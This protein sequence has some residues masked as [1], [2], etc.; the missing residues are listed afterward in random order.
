MLHSNGKTTAFDRKPITPIP[1]YSTDFTDYAHPSPT[2]IT[3]TT[4]RVPYKNCPGTYSSTLPHRISIRHVHTSSIAP[5]LFH[6]RSGEF[7]NKPI[8]NFPA[9]LHRLRMDTPLF[10]RTPIRSLPVDDVGNFRCERC[11]DPVSPEKLQCR[12]ADHPRKNTLHPTQNHQGCRTASHNLIRD[13]GSTQKFRLFGQQSV[14]VRNTPAIKRPYSRP[15]SNHA[16]TI[17]CRKKINNPLPFQILHSSSSF[18]RF[19]RVD[20]PFSTPVTTHSPTAAPSI[21]LHPTHTPPVT[22]LH[23]FGFVCFRPPKLHIF[24]KKSFFLFHF[25][26]NH[27]LRNVLSSRALSFVLFI[28]YTVLILDIHLT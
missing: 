17:F 4:I 8:D 19:T 1:D 26:S 7:T 20:H 3:S 6:R 21:L 27:T 9:L 16:R 10:Q 18:H 24:S 12:R 15:V 22:V 2:S 13:K 25:T 5:L 11:I 28:Q 23:A 14:Q